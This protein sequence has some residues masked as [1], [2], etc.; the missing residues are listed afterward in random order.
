MLIHKFR[1]GQIVLLKL[2]HYDRAP[3]GTY[4]VVKRLPEHEG[5]FEYQVRNSTE[6]HERVVRESQL[7]AM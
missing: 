6:P 2:A 4:I 1:I 7:R 3:G 5:E